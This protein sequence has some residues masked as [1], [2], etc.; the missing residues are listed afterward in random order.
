MRRSRSSG[1]LQYVIGSG[2]WRVTRSDEGQPFYCAVLEGGCRLALDGENAVELRAGDFVLV[3]ATFGIT[4]S[5]LAAPMGHADSVPA[6]SGGGVFR[7]GEVDGPA[8]L[9]LIGG[10][11]SFDSPDAALLVSLLP[12]LI[13]V[14]DDSRLASLVR[15]VSDESRNA[16]PAREAILAR[17][18]EVLLI[19]ALRSGPGTTGSPGLVRGL[20]DTRLAAALRAMHR[21]PERPWSTDELAR[22]SALS[23]SAFF[24]RFR[25]ALDMAPIAYLLAWRMGWRRTCFVAKGSLC[26]KFPSAWDM[27]QPARS[28]LPS[29][30][31]WGNHQSAMPANLEVWLRSLR[32]A[33]RRRVKGYRR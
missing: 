24:N 10:H 7:I 13:H 9:H 29:P 16:R 22:E 5:S 31:T 32:E 8:D 27:A 6:A 28:A 26:R 25:E 3:P 2:T 33:R 23:R 30:V 4:M 21:A 12:R 14:R 11:C 19:E 15:L 1:W 20:A 17:L 18:L